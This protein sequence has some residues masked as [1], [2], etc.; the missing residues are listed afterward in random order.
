MARRRLLWQLFPAFLLVTL[1]SLLGVTWYVTGQVKDFYYARME[2]D[3]LARARL[4]EDRVRAGL[5]DGDRVGIQRFCAEAGPASATRITVMLPDGVV[6]GDSHETPEVMENHAGP[7]RPEMVGALDGEPA[8]A[9]RQSPT[10]RKLMMYVA[11]PVRDGDKL[12]G[13][14]RTAVPIEAIDEGLASIRGRIAAAGVAAAVLAALLSLAIS[15]RVSRPLEAIRCGADRFAR[16]DLSH[17]LPVDGP[18]E[19]GSLAETMN[20]MAAD[21]DD[22]IKTVI[23]Q[24]N[25]RE[26]ILSSM[27]EGVLAVDR[28]QVVIS[29]NRAAA[30]LLGVDGLHAPGRA[31]EEV[32]RNPELLKLVRQVLSSQAPAVSEIVLYHQRTRFLEAHGSVLRDAD[33]REIGALVVLADVTRIKRLESV[34]RDFVANVSHE[35]KTPVTSIKGFVETLLDGAMHNPEDAE[36]FLK[37]VGTQADRLG[38]IIEDLLTLSRIEQEAEKA[39]IVLERGPLAEVLR[40]AVDVCRMKAQEKNVTLELSC[41]AGLEAQRNPPLLE[42]AVVNLIDNAIKYSA[43]G[44]AVSVEAARRG[45]EIAIAVA[46]RGCGIPRQHLDRIFER[47]YRVDKARSRKLGGTGLGL[48]I[49]KHI[50]Q[51]HHGRATVES[52][53]GQGSVFTIHLPAEGASG[54]EEA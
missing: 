6:V 17:K 11:V 14:V 10:L 36:R 31:M 43:E 12:L 41:E 37:I 22:R 16:G 25:E 26:A 3:L 4:V 7:G 50:A 47:F 53:V 42:Q 30:E 2:D 44:Q 21:L 48:S 45:D 38:G 13:V 8:H 46:D 20:Q 27:T 15:R 24:R 51:A 39:E 52:T 40:A 5:K 23:A 34:R 18:L 54:T 32:S 28:G 29:L 9:V 19:V 35:L 33:G 49:V 1:A